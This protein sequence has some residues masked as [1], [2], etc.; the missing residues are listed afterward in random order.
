M[1]WNGASLLPLL[2][3]PPRIP[4]QRQERSIQHSHTPYE[5]VSLTLLMA[6][7]TASCGSHNATD[8]YQYF[9][10]AAAVPCGPC[11]ELTGRCVCRVCP[12]SP[13]KFSASPK[14]QCTPAHF[15][16]ALGTRPSALSLN[17][18]P[19]SSVTAHTSYNPYLLHTRLWSCGSLMVH[20]LRLLA[21]KQAVG[22]GK[23]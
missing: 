6:R 12:T 16:R 5:S 21:S 4:R 19:S 18:H 23:A 22:I 14:P 15:C 8:S 20:L 7:S 3:L 10:P 17:L 11:V 2:S 13:C 1:G 9:E